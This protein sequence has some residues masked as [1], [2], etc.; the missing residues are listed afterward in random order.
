MR[1]PFCKSFARS[2]MPPTMAGEPKSPKRWMMKVHMAMALARRWTG[3][4]SNNSLQ[5]GPV[6]R[7][8]EEHAGGQ[9]GE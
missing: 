6:G 4:I 7:K 1:T 8:D 5:M 2:A 3:T 9:G